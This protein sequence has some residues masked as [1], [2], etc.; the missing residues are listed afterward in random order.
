[1]SGVLTSAKETRKKP[2]KLQNALEELAE[3]GSEENPPRTA[4]S[5]SDDRGGEAD[6]SQASGR[7]EGNVNTLK[8]M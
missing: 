6:A 4:Q 2:M 7:V 8:K 3:R 1:M 5:E